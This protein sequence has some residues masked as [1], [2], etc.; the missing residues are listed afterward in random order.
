MTTELIWIAVP[1]AGFCLGLLPK[2]RTAFILVG[3]CAVV[4]AAYALSWFGEDAQGVLFGF[5]LFGGGWA[6]IL[7]FLGA[8]LGSVARNYALMGKGRY[9]LLICALVF[10]AAAVFALNSMRQDRVLPDT[11][12]GNTEWVMDSGTFGDAEM[13]RAT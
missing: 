6:A 8:M 1:L 11:Q 10:G 2:P 12:G 13:R 3:T 5:I 7:L 4:A 9:T